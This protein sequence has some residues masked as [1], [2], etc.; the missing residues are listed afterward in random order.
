MDQARQDLGDSLTG[1]APTNAREIGR[2][3]VK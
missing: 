3:E 1:I 2:Q